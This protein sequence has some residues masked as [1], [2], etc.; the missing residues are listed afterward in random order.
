[1]RP[2]LSYQYGLLRGMTDFEQDPPPSDQCEKSDIVDP[3][4]KPE[5]IW[6]LAR[7]L[8]TSGQ[9][10]HAVCMALGIR[11]STF[12][13]RASQEN[14]L[15]RDQPRAPALV[16]PLDMTACVDD[17]AT[18]RDKAWRRVCLAMDQGRSAEAM[19]W[20]R[21][22]AA[23]FAQTQTQRETIDRS[24]DGPARDDPERPVHRAMEKLHD[25]LRDMEFGEGW[26]KVESTLADSHQD[27]LARTPDPAAPGLSRAERRRRLKY[28]T[29][30][31]PGMPSS[32][33]APAAPP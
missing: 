29:S 23:L 3:F 22:H 18:A 30:H 12:W 5:D 28:S 33:P 17:L 4:E 16:E 7:E 2:N 10:G 1:M 21:V 15:R 25:D 27:H 19:R 9:T 14:W 24:A 31:R 32:G 6:A 11:P 26:E 8:Y 20:I 13:R